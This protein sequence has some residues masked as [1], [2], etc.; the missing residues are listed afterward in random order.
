MH[1]ASLTLERDIRYGPG[2]S[3]AETPI[4]LTS[5]AQDL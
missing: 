3:G 2:I 5:Y 1:R 4:I